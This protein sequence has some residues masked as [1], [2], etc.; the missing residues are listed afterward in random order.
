MKKDDRPAEPDPSRGVSSPVTAIAAHPASHAAHV[1]SLSHATLEAARRGERAARDALVRLYVDD[2]YKA[3]ARILVGRPAA[4][5]DV[6]QDAMLRVLRG[7]GDFEPTGAATLRTWI[8]TIT[9]RT[10]IDAL[11]RQGRY[12]ARLAAVRAVPTPAVPTP[13]VVAEQREL[14]ARVAAAMEELPTDQRVALVL[15]A[16][17]DQDYAEIAAATD[18]SIAG[19][20]SRLNRARAALAR[21]LGRTP[22]EAA[23]DR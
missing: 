3:V 14:A 22:M 12:E 4:W 17:H 9:A 10:A 6:A 11:R 1:G 21:L 16:Y 2:V 23:D 7:L 18:S 8:L 15:R 13:D 5:D 19:V 20:K